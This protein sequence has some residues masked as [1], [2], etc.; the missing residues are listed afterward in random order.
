MNTHSGAG[1]RTAPSPRA[2]EHKGVPPSLAQGPPRVPAQLWVLTEHL[3]RAESYI[4]WPRSPEHRHTAVSASNES[5]ETNPP[6]LTPEA[7]G[8][9]RPTDLP[10]PLCD[11]EDTAQPGPDPGPAGPP[12]ENER[13]GAGLSSRQTARVAP[14]RKLR[15]RP[16]GARG[17]AEQGPGGGGGRAGP[18]RAGPSGAREGQDRVGGRG[19][20]FSGTRGGRGR[21]GPGE[22]PVRPPSVTRR[23]LPA[24]KWARPRVHPRARLCRGAVS[25]SLLCK[26]APWL[27][28][29]VPATRDRAPR[30]ARGCRPGPTSQQARAWRPSPPAA[31][32]WPPTTTTGAAWVPLPATA[33]AA[34]PSAPGKPFPTPQ[35]SAGPLLSPSAPAPRSWQH[36][37]PTLLLSGLPKADPG[38]WWASF[39]FGKSTL[40]FMATV[41]ESAEHPE[42][43]QASSSM[44]TGG[45]ARDAPRKQPGGQSSTA[46]AGPPS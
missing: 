3:A 11:G 10:D 42:P 46:S 32:S 22:E 37:D 24:H 9:R 35:V 40:P 4:R 44:T 23:G 36:Q 29:P 2:R 26:W 20:G 17:G 15:A 45:L 39:F 12:S 43:P 19:G 28:V 33:P 25:R 41:L 5:H 31:R 1:P 30:P 34:V 27:S 16:S 6:R 18:R 38:H 8:L 14:R 7:L 21:V 13:H